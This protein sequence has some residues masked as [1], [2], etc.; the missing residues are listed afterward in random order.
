M[1]SG[2]LQCNTILSGWILRA[3]LF[4]TMW[5][6]VRRHLCRPSLAPS[7]C[8]SYIRPRPPW[9]PGCSSSCCC[10]SCTCMQ[11]AAL[12]AT[13]SSSTGA[14][15]QLRRL[16]ATRGEGRGQIAAGRVTPR[17]TCSTPPARSL[18]LGVVSWKPLT[19]VTAR[20]LS[21]SAVRQA[22]GSGPMSA[23][24]AATHPHGAATC[25]EMGQSQ[26]AIA[27]SATRLRASL[28]SRMLPGHIN[29]M[30]ARTPRQS[31]TIPVLRP[32]SWQ[33]FCR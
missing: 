14:T 18:T 8:T 25:Q 31:P 33:V 2:S 29:A 28:P 3:Q 19:I 9:P 16:P 13:M 26:A 23:G 10:R 32:F 17:Q 21:V 24:L 5:H 7:N 12:A 11:A 6:A 20:S 22:A 4:W 27:T 1:R 15:V 30:R